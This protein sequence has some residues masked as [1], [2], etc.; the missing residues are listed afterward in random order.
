MQ[1]KDMVELSS[2]W[3]L[4]NGASLGDTCR[5]RNRPYC[6][7]IQCDVPY[8]ENIADSF[9]VTWKDSRF[10][11]RNHYVLCTK[12]ARFSCTLV[13]TLRVETAIWCSIRDSLPKILFRFKAGKEIYFFSKVSRPV[14]GTNHPL[15]QRVKGLLS[16]R[17]KQRKRNA[18]ISLASSFEFKN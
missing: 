5:V 16:L 8:K 12:E 9:G 1:K 10:D 6:L 13:Q 11:T 4:R 15:I 2:R 3:K 17:V 14:L 7:T 18:N